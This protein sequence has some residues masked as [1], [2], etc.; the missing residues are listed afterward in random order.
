MDEAHIY[1][2]GEIIDHMGEDNQAYGYVSPIDVL[3]QLKEVSE[4]ETILVHIN[5]YGGSVAGGF[6][7]YDILR[8]S[9]KTINTQIEG[10]AMSIATVIALAGDKRYATK[11]SEFLIHNPMGVAMGTAEEIEEQGKQIKDVENKIAEIYAKRAGN[12]TKSKALKE[13]KKDVTMSLDQAKEYGFITDIV[14]TIKAV[15]KFNSNDM[16]DNTKLLEGIKNFLA[17]KKP[18]VKNVMLNT[19]NGKQ[20]IFNIENGEPKEGDTAT[21][22]GEPAKGEIKMPEGLVY[23]FNESGK[24]ETIVEPA[25]ETEDL[26]EELV[27]KVIEKVEAKFDERLK[28]LVTEDSIKDMVKADVIENIKKD[29]QGNK[30]VVEKIK[31]LSGDEFKLDNKK[32]GNNTDDGRSLEAKYNMPAGFGKK[33]NE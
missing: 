27:N 6:A 23:N 2:Y 24:L 30:E 16:S 19:A 12:I 15:A 25:D 1:I 14:D 21:L 26:V 11:N 28:G 10:K 20:L 7:I 29:V 32:E 4:A 5:S 13:M 9:G 8:A 31:A 18:E 33:N 22:E 17:G 3:A